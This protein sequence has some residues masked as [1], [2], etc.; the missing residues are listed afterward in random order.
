MHNPM[1]LK[2][3]VTLG[4]A[5]GG[6][7]SMVAVMHGSLDWACY[8]M[9][10][11]WVFDSFDGVVARM[12]G[13]GNKFGSV[14]DNAAD[15]I[16]Y[17]LAPSLIIYLA[18]TRPVAEGGAGWP[19]VVSF[20]L[21]SF[22][23]AFGVVRFARNNVKDIILPE[24]HLGLPRTAYGLY[25]ATLFTSHIFH[26]PW[27]EGDNHLQ[28]VLYICAAVFITATSFLTFT[29][30]PYWAKPTRGS[31]AGKLVVF[32]VYW[33]LISSL[34]ALVVG[35]LFI[36]DARL[37]ADALFLNFTIY[38]WL[39]P[40]SIPKHKRREVRRYTQELIREW[41]EEMGTDAR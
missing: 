11:A 26:N 23:T 31:G 10:I 39:G 27:I 38:V 33:F 32:S 17:S 2:D 30:L 7:A 41:N 20:I 24:F 18:F 1:K 37:F 12:T 22:P 6:L 16:A 9:V 3:Y 36:G 15:L 21:A 29:F 4:N 13:G 35:V 34:G 28:G 8:F 5:L 25:I 40:L 14:L 19:M